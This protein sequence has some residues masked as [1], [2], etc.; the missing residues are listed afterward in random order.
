MKRT[1]STLA[2][3]GDIWLMSGSEFVA[4]VAGDA[5]VAPR[6]AGAAD[7]AAV[8]GGNGD[9]APC[10]SLEAWTTVVAHDGGGR[11]VAG[12]RLPVAPVGDVRRYVNDTQAYIIS[13][14]MG[15]ADLSTL[16]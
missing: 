14:P 10:L 12:I 8:A 2:E 15:E 9:G 6:A 1:P 11:G 7:G 3:A 5:E 16:G 4:L 13:L